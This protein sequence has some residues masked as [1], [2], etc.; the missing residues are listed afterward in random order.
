MDDAEKTNSYESIFLTKESPL[1]GTSEVLDKNT[2]LK[3]FDW[4]WEDKGNDLML[5]MHVDSE[6]IFDDA[7]E[8]VS[9]LEEDNT[10]SIGSS[11]KR[12]A[13]QILAQDLPGVNFKEYVNL[14]GKEEN[15]PLLREFVRLLH[16]LPV[17][18]YLMLRKVSL[19]VYF[20]AEARAIDSLLEEI[21]MQWVATHDVPH[22][23]NNYR[24]VHIT[25]FSLLLLNSNLHNELSQSKFTRDE[26]VE[27]TIFAL[28]NESVN[29]DKSALETELGSYYDLLSVD[30]LPLYKG[31]SASAAVKPTNFSSKENLIP[32]RIKRSVS[33][34]S[35]LSNASSNWERT[36]TAKCAFGLTNWRYH[37][38]QPLPQLYFPESCDA[39]MKHD[40]TSYWMADDVLQFQEPLSNSPNYPALRKSST[41]FNPSKRKFFGWFRHS[42]TASIFKEHEEESLKNSKWF[43]ARVRV[44][45]GRLYIFNFKNCQALS[46]KTSDLA[47]CRSRAF[48]YT[49][50]N[51]FGATATLLQNNIVYNSNHKRWNFTITFPRS[52]DCESQRVYRFQTKDMNVAQKF[53][54]S[55]LMWSAR[56]T[57][58]PKTQFEMVSNQE[59]GWS[60]RLLNKTVRPIS[61]ALSHWTPLLGIESIYEEIED[62]GH[63]TLEDRYYNLK[64]FTEKLVQLIDKHNS[65]K[66]MMIEIWSL[67][68]SADKF[69]IAM[70]NWNRRYL[71]L[72]AMYEKHNLYLKALEDLIDN[73]DDDFK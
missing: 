58:I 39:R 10:E 2:I 27:N 50:L 49:V 43:N 30:Q 3:L 32:N 65:Y 73:N 36:K 72:I 51:L 42:P 62:V 29:I 4:N 33:N 67:G 66:P 56:I 71:F 34:V 7:H 25:L 52:I 64:V 70:D 57:P 35:D 60:E 20:I 53:V 59:Y 48:S 17:S 54:R 18:L 69:D 63:V 11:Y 14:M 61:V 44:A 5:E 6:T 15:R 45:E 47:S 40:D 16:P 19:S 68:S 8:N 12:E 46:P 21:S 38:D 26:F 28:L 31:P 41:S 1:F 24:L 13:K 55:T 9:S 37:H 23:E 22:Y